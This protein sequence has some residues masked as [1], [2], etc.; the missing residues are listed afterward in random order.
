VSLPTRGAESPPLSL[1]R[2]DRRTTASVLRRRRLRCGCGQARPERRGTLPVFLSDVK[3]RHDKMVGL[4]ETI[5]S[6]IVGGR[7]RRRL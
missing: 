7:N 3:T 1:R 6:Y 2:H 5:S 4:V